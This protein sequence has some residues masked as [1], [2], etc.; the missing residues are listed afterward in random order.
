MREVKQERTGRRDLRLSLRHRLCGFDCPAVDI[1]LLV[2][3]DGGRAAAI[4][5]YKNENAPEVALSESNIKA[6]IDLGNRAGIPVIGTRYAKDFAWWKTTP[7][8]DF[9]IQ[10][11]NT[12]KTSLPI[13]EK[14]WVS[15]LYRL[16]GRQIPP[17]LFPLPNAGSA[18]PRS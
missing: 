10:K 18:Q 4:V 5:E 8:N 11:L 12:D 14:T 1:D 6:L 9:A 13:S 2:E 15:I 17:D 16:R 3:F 7:L